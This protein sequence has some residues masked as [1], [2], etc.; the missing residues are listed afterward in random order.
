[1]VKIMV[2]VKGLK[3]YYNLRKDIIF[4][5]NI[6]IKAA[7]DVSFSIPEGRTL[8]MVG[9]SG[10]GKSTIAS[11]ILKLIEPDAGKIV[12]K[13]T[14]ITKLK[15]E[16][17]R[18]FRK[19]MQLVFQDP[20]GSLNPKMTAGRIITEPLRIHT[21]LCKKEINERLEELLFFVGLNPDHSDRYPS[22]FS[23]GQR[24]RI[25]IA[26]AIALN[27][28]FIVLDEPVSA[29]DVSIQGQILNLLSDLQQKLKLTY[30]FIAHNLAAVE[31]IS[32]D[33]IVMY[34]GRIVEKSTKEKLYSNPLHPYTKSLLKS[35]PENKP[36]KHG[37]SVI[38]GEIP[39]P[40]DPPSGCYFHPRCP[41]AKNICRKEY[42]E[43]K[44]SE[45]TSVACFL[46]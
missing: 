19:N 23:G 24:Q 22:E 11:S 46:Y 42:P 20:Y 4:R 26:R 9:E 10:S 27:P 1:M 29:L 30:L 45:G 32:D 16:K 35:I 38:S 13:G 2:T 12:I 39:S 7:D 36:V 31:H 33:I 44:N 3:K 8:G 5:K 15:G 43:L 28:E 37:F 6:L 21:K 17:L 18:K 34:L 40:E 25:S 41:Y 14:D